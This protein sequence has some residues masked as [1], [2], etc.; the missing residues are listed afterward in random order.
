MT[1]IIPAS[2]PREAIDEIAKELLRRSA[3]S[4]SYADGKQSK[5][6]K[7]RALAEA[8]ALED[9]AIA[10]IEADVNS[11]PRQRAI[12][13]DDHLIEAIALLQSH[14]G[15]RVVLN[16]HSATNGTMLWIFRGA[17][18]IGMTAHGEDM[19]PAAKW[20]TSRISKGMPTSAVMLDSLLQAIGHIAEARS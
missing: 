17:D 8:I 13:P 4:R 12:G 11:Q 1:L 18:Q 10:I 5:T 19:Q 9:F 14:R 2:S 6:D 3:V 7:T 16:R 15:L 20:R